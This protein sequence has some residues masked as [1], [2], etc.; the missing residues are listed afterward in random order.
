MLEQAVWAKKDKILSEFPHKLMCSGWDAK[1]CYDFILAGCLA[2][3]S[4]LREWTKGSSPSTSSTSWYR[5]QEATMSLPAISQFWAL[6]FSWIWLSAFTPKNWLASQVLI[7][8]MDFLSK[9]FMS[10]ARTPTQGPSK[11]MFVKKCC[12]VVEYGK[13]SIWYDIPEPGSNVCE[14]KHVWFWR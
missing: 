4:S 13:L 8:Y 1:Q 6:W 12:R 9:R 11:K 2:T 14:I 3:I 7:L 10:R 5:P